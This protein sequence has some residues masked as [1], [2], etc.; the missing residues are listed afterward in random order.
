MLHKNVYP[1]KMILLSFSLIVIEKKLPFLTF[2]QGAHIQWWQAR[3]F[4]NIFKN[5]NM[6]HRNLETIIFCQYNHLKL[7][8]VKE[9]KYLSAF[10]HCYLSTVKSAAA[11]HFRIFLHEVHISSPDKSERVDAAVPFQTFLQM[12]PRNSALF[13]V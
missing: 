12:R 2:W 5:C 1:L 11:S 4:W 6:Q 7:Y 8:L 13:S 9:V 3:K 10:H